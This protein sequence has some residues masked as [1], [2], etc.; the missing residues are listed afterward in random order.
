MGNA[1][2]VFGAEKGTGARSAIGVA[3]LP[4]R[5]PPLSA[6]RL[7]TNSRSPSLFA[8]V[9]LTPPPFPLNLGSLYLIFPGFLRLTLDGGSQVGFAVEVEAIF[10]L[11]SDYGASFSLFSTLFEAHFGRSLLILN[12]FWEI[13]T[14]LWTYPAA[15]GP[16]SSKL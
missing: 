1:W 16:G 2:Q 5:F 10:Q 6:H 8:H 7:N 14:H 3:S 11:K 15:C 4:V 9:L 12:S 13:V